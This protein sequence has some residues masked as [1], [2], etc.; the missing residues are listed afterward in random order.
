M[1]AGSDRRG[2]LLIPDILECLADQAREAVSHRE[3]ARLFGGAE[4]IRQRIGAVRFKT[5]DAGFSS[6]RAPCK[7]IS[8]TSTPSW[9]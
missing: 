3:A 9:A 1:N 8:P 2:G 5:Y 7:P 4:S 6:H